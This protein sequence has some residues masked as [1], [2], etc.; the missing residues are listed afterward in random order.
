MNRSLIPAA[1]IILRLTDTSFPS[2]SLAVVARTSSEVLGGNAS[3]H[4]AFRFSLDAGQTLALKEPHC[5]CQ[6]TRSQLDHC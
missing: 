2:T 5:V 3:E 1:N 6:S 4:L